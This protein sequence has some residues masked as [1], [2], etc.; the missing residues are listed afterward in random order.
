MNQKPVVYVE[1]MSSK[2]ALIGHLFGRTCLA[3]ALPNLY[4]TV[5][6]TTYKGSKDTWKINSNERLSY[7]SIDV[8]LKHLQRV[9]DAF[10]YGGGFFVQSNNSFPQ[11][12][13]LS[14]SV[15]SF[16]ALTACA[17][18]AVQARSEGKQRLTRAQAAALSAEGKTSAQH[19]FYGPWSIVENGGVTEASFGDFDQLHHV[20]LVVTSQK[21]R[22]TSEQVCSLI[23][24]NERAE[25]YEKNVNQRI[26]AV[27]KHL[28]EKNWKGVFECVW[29]DFTELH[30]VFVTSKP[31]F[32]FLTQE[33]KDI[34]GQVRRWWDIYEDGPIVM[35]GIG[36][37]VHLIFRQDQYDMKEKMLRGLTFIQA[38][39]GTCWQTSAVS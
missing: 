8:Y 18:K 14:S 34:L 15:S 26:V 39:E 11:G 9:K 31:S 10:D 2:V 29:E 30:G 21:K 1:K 35:M 20:A 23:G 3:Y 28:T 36:Y 38:I 4:T 24:N 17:V 13:G 32:S 22:I 6:L 19:A 5:C 12:L 37:V 33:A 7:Q 27:R 16:A 25:V